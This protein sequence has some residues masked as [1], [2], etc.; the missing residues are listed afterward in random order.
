[1]DLGT[2]LKKIKNKQY[3]TL[4]QC[5]E[6][7]R[8]VWN[9]CMTYNADGSDFY[10]LADK[11]QK[12]FETKYNKLLQDIGAAKNAATTETSSAAAASSSNKVSLQEKRNMAKQ[13]YQISKEDLGKFLIEVESKCPPAIKRNATEDELEFNID[14]I[15]ATAMPQLMEFLKVYVCDSSR[16]GP[17]C[18]SLLKVRAFLCC[19]RHSPRHIFACFISLAAAA[20]GSSRTPNP[21]RQIPARRLR[22]NPKKQR[23]RQWL[24]RKSAPCRMIKYLIAM[25]ASF[26]ETFATT[27]KPL[28]YFLTLVIYNLGEPIVP[29][30]Q[31]STRHCNLLSLSLS[32]LVMFQQSS[33]YSKTH[34]PT[35]FP[36]KRVEH[37]VRQLDG[38]LRRRRGTATA[39]RALG[40]PRIVHQR[41][42]I[43]HQH[44]PRHWSNEGRLHVPRRRHEGHVRNGVHAKLLNRRP[45]FFQIAIDENEID[46]VFVFEFNLTQRWRRR[47]ALFAPGRPKVHHCWFAVAANDFQRRRL[48]LEFRQQLDRQQRVRPLPQIARDGQRHGSDCHGHVAAALLRG[49]GLFLLDGGG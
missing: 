34:S 17:L 46:L 47:L 49:D 36:R 43:L 25:D 27:R 9:N 15:T 21:K 19:S 37:F 48:L 30:N 2:V 42:Q 32:F 3:S 18:C 14:A 31:P 41:V 23:P 45:G 33:L 24:L 29:T 39:D 11:L 4:Y 40:H 7:V 8:L 5:G 26:W 44:Q 13:M 38:Q 12:A 20:A 28:F 10:K 6:D 22:A 1:M 16:F 35:R